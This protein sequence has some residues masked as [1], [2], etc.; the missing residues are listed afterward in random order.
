VSMDVEVGRLAIRCRGGAGGSRAL[1]A[2]RRLEQVAR[3]P[4]PA[5][6]ARVLGDIDAEVD[7]LEVAMDLDPLAYDSE[8][9]ATLWADR[10]RVALAAR[11]TDA[12]EPSTSRRRPSASVGDA[13]AEPSFTRAAHRGPDGWTSEWQRLVRL[14][15]AASPASLASLAPAVVAEGAMSRSWAA[16]PTSERSRVLRR[17]RSAIAALATEPAGVA[18]DGGPGAA[19]GPS[20]RPHVPRQRS[21]PATSSWEEAWRALARVAGRPDS[22]GRAAEPPVVLVEALAAAVTSDRAVTSSARRTVSEVGGLVLL[23]PWLGSYLDRSASILDELHPYDARRIALSLI[24][25]PYIRVDGEGPQPCAEAMRLQHDP[26][27]RSLAGSGPDVDTLDLDLSSMPVAMRDAVAGDAEALLRTF[28]GFL[29]G[30]ERSTPGFLR[31]NLV[32]RPAE[33]EQAEDGAIR[34]TLL[35]AALDVLVARLPYPLGTFA[36][37]WTPQLHVQLEVR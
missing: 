18:P 30:F 13:V 6:L 28:A 4:L 1:A 37:A 34:I 31:R 17:L 25:A 33:I 7:R 3:G 27:V 11:L 12:P 21:E 16:V 8:T 20:R 29:P 35:P 32:V 22:S 23:Y 2:R 10:I 26:L 9:L 36:L 24:A 15:M 19:R 5:A 14:I